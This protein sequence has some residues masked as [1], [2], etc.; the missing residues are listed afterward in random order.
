MTD[1]KLS[2]FMLDYP[3]TEL[4]EQRA[5][6]DVIRMCKKVPGAVNANQTLLCERDSLMQS[7]TV[8]MLLC[9]PNTKDGI[10]LEL[11]RVQ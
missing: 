10:D 9:E 6:H 4:I 2:V 7:V 8:L 5:D 1:F 3:G 11:D